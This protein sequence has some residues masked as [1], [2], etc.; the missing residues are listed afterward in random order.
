MKQYD[1][2]DLRLKDD[3]KTSSTS[4][5]QI[6]MWRNADKNCLDRGHRLI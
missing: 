1:S 6:K 5:R 2:K 4:L 3:I